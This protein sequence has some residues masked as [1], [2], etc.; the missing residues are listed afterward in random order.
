MTDEFAF[1][2]DLEVDALTELVNIGVSR[3]A[4]SLRQMVGR[5]VV[6]SVPSIEVTS[7]QT[8]AALMAEREVGPL[9][10]VSQDFEGAFRRPAPCCIFPAGQQ[11]GAGQG[12][13][14]RSSGRG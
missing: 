13:D 1:L 14:R 3:A 9:L 12:G 5:Q 8:A 4:A 2:S 11:P 7:R 10:A 6:L